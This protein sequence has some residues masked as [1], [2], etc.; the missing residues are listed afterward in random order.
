MATRI[1]KTS[2]PIHGKN[3]RR[4]C[5]HKKG[6]KGGGCRE[7]PRLLRNPSMVQDTPRRASAWLRNY[8]SKI[9][10]DV[11]YR[12][13]RCGTRLREISLSIVLG[14]YRARR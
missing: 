3:G 6:S 7:A 1:K 2:V 4:S 5:S 8:I 11:S 13:I 12:T 14:S 9:L 10:W